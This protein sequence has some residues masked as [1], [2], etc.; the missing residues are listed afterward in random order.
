MPKRKLA[1]SWPSGAAAARVERAIRK[2][3]GEIELRRY[4]VG[5]ARREST[6]EPRIHSVVQAVTAALR[7]EAAVQAMDQ[8]GLVPSPTLISPKPRNVLKFVLGKTARFEG[9]RFVRFCEKPRLARSKPM[10]SR[11]SGKSCCV[12]P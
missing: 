1:R 4:V 3:R 6:I 9:I 2:T 12:M 5:I 10:L 8:T 7:T 11:F